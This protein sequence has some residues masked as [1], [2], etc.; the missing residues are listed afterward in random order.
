MRVRLILYAR[1]APHGNNLFRTSASECSHGEMRFV[2]GHYY[3][4]CGLA[5]L[6]RSWI[7]YIVCGA[8][9]TRS[10]LHR[11]QQQPFSLTRGAIFA[12]CLR[13]MWSASR[14]LHSARSMP[15]G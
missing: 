5:R 12:F 9:T 13:S 10:Y 1:E 14:L 4:I 15:S 3:L 7:P 11:T 6:S 8:D 2:A